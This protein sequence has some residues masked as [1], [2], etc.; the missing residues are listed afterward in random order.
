MRHLSTPELFGAVTICLPQDVQAEAYDYPAEFFE[1]RIYRRPRQGAI[2]TEIEEAANLIRSAKRPMVVAGGGVF[3]SNAGAVLKTWAQKTGIPVTATQAGTSSLP[4]T[5]LNLGGIGVT[6]TSAANEIASKADLVLAIGTRL[7]DFTTASKSQ[8]QAQGVRFLSIN[9][10]AM[11]AAKHGAISLCGD[12]KAVLEQ[13]MLATSDHHVSSAYEKE[14]MG[15]REKW[16]SQRNQITH[17]EPGKRR[18]HQAEVI[19]V[20]NTELDARSTIVHAAGGLPGDLHKLWESRGEGDYHSE[21]GYSCMG[22]EI[23][24]ALGV[25]FADP[26]REVYAV[27]GDGSYL[28]LNHEIVTSIQEGRKITVVMLDNHGYQCIHNLQRSQGSKGFGNEFRTRTQRGLTGEPVAVDYVANA[29]SL[30]AK[31]FR[32]ESEMGLIDA[33]RAAR[34]ESQTCLIYV[35]IE[36]NT[37]LPGFS[38]WDVPVAETSTMSSVKEARAKYVEALKNERFHY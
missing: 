8:F 35:P 16:L 10:N 27:L 17:P 13:L 6:G 14:I 18:L 25:K 9:I 22:Y 30:G 15:L 28:M 20:L 26:G 12:A 33:L 1:K 2:V 7:S 31:T 5:Q 34:K 11:D 32:A 19:R 38:W 37:P 3:Y 29:A 36:A 4:P 24:G 23:A 21:Y